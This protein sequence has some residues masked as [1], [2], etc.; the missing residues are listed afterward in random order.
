MYTAS[1]AFHNAVANGAHQIALLIF[2]DAVFSNDDIDVSRGISFNDY[3]NTEENLAIGQVLSNE[4]SFSLFNDV[5]VLN[6]YEFGDFLATIGAQTGNETVTATGTVQASSA[7]H[8]YVAN[9]TEPYITIDGIEAATQPSGP[10]KSILIYDGIVYCFLSD[11]TSCIGY[12]DA[13]GSE[14]RVSL[15]AFMLEQMKKW[16]GKGIFYNKSTR[17]LKIWQV[18]NLRTYEF[19][20]LGVFTAERPNVPSLIE[21]DFHCYDR[22]MKFEKDMPSD[23]AL[24]ITYPVTFGNL[25]KALCDYVNVPYRTTTFIN[26]T[27]TISARP[28]DF[29]RVTMRDVL[30]WIAEAACANARFDRDGYL[31]MDWLR[32]TEQ[33]FDESG[34]SEFR[35]YWYETKQI[36][37]LHN[38]ASDGSYEKISGSG[39]EAYLIQD[40]PLLKG[41]N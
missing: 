13:D 11:N 2:D 12:N 35:P 10:V 29:D 21:I 27:A 20:P 30:R 34:Y 18:T 19:V 25:M 24:G 38:R 39:T 33:T 8:V 28:D 41:V 3:F 32:T 26:S 4:L 7:D 15:N 5:G 14:A 37:R 6:D 40:N 1:A 9:A 22:M 17:I 31:I 36:T 16:D 23:A